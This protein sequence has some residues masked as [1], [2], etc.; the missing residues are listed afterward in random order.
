MIATAVARGKGIMVGSQAS[1][2]LGTA[3]AGLFAAR[4][5]VDH[6]SEL[7]FFLKLTDEIVTEPLRLTDG[8]LAV[9]DLERVAI[10]PDRLLHFAVER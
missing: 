10:D 7:S 9:A 6:P 2:T 8:W 4:P 3:R 1:T 5:E